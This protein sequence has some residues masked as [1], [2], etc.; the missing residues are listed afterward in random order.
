M[1][2]REIYLEDIPLEDALA[3]FWSALDAAG[4]LT[5]L[6]AESV[7]IDKAL[8]RV[9]A[10]PVFARLSVPHYHAA[11]MDGIAVRAD[12]T[13]GASE[14][15]PLHL[16][17]ETQAIWIDTGDPLPAETNAVIMA[18]QVQDLG[19]GHLEIL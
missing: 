5:P 15:N 13:L 1:S 17:V 19:G 18:E 2:P 14:T 9:T 7:E 12:D 16:Q 10:E 3:R 4:A 11:A 6:P 8:G